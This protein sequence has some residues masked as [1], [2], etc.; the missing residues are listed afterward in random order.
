MICFTM[1][2]PCTSILPK[3]ERNKLANYNSLRDHKNEGLGI[4]CT[5]DLVRLYCAV[6]ISVVQNIISQKSIFHC[7]IS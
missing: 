7:K 1:L 6:L 3:Y 4:W 5:L 2:V